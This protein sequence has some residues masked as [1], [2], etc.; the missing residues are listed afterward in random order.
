MSELFDG[1]DDGLKRLGIVHGKVGENLT[2]ETD[3]LLGEFAHELG[4]GDPVLTR[5]G[6]DPLDPKGAEVALLGLAVAIGVGE[7][8]LV[9]VLGDCP[10]ILAGQE[11]TAGSLENLLA[12]S[13]RGY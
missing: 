1:I 10:D 13:P 5:G 8:L 12:A 4:I 2:V 7:T 9:G 6:V 11:V 3:I